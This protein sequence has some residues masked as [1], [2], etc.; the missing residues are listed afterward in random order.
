MPN[1]WNISL[2]YYYT[3]CLSLPV[4][5]IA[6]P[7]L[8]S[9]MFRQVSDK[10]QITVFFISFFFRGRKFLERS[11]KSNENYHYLGQLQVSEKR[12]SSIIHMFIIQSLIDC[13]IKSSLPSTV[14]SLQQKFKKYEVVRCP[15]TFRGLWT[16]VELTGFDRKESEQ[17]LNPTAIGSSRKDWLTRLFSFKQAELRVF[18]LFFWRFFKN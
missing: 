16:K 6:F 14:F 5:V 3:L 8:Y 12:N 13:S 11:K 18:S 15:A 10:L 1:R 17:I 2:N 4:Y 7:Q 9:H